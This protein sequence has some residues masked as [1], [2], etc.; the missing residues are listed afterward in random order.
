MLSK[1]LTHFIPSLGQGG[2]W[3]WGRCL[4][5]EVDETPHQLTVVKPS[6]SVMKLIAVAVSV[7]AD[8]TESSLA[9]RQCASFSSKRAISW[10][11]LSKKRVPP[12]FWTWMD[13]VNIREMLCFLNNPILESNMV[14]VPVVMRRRERE[15]AWCFLTVLVNSK[16]A[17]ARAKSVGVSFKAFGDVEVMQG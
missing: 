14:P 2:E 5:G 7:E 1:G 3:L 17:A 8:V 9:N 12:T 4:G 16:V 11:V 15:S 13:T 6:G 10:R